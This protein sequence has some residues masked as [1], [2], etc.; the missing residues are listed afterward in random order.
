MYRIPP[1][2]MERQK[3]VNAIELSIIEALPTGV[4]YGYIVAALTNVLHRMVDRMVTLIP[5]EED[6]DAD[7]R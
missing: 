7:A 6:D 4:E 3:R 2:E 5:D 1:E